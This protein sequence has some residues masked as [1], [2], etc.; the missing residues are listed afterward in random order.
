MQN[1][2]QQRE[3][4]GMQ[5]QLGC[6]SQVSAGGNARLHTERCEAVCC[7]PSIFNVRSSSVSDAHLCRCISSVWT[8]ETTLSESWIDHNNTKKEHISIGVF[9]CQNFVQVFVLLKT[10]S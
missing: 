1:N 9:L 8:E 3:W 10:F 2:H 6:Q 7:Q 4:N 5:R